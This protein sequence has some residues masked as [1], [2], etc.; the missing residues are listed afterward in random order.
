LGSDE[1]RQPDL[2][3]ATKKAEFLA[4][5]IDASS[6]RVEAASQLRKAL[7]SGE[8]ILTVYDVFWTSARTFSMFAFVLFM[9]VK[10]GALSLFHKRG[11]GGNTSPRNATYAR[12]KYA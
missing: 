6:M 10:S 3:V 9:A 4:N 1:R 12:G 11:R 7:N 8:D 2:N 5:V